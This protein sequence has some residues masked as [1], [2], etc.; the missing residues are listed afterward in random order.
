MGEGCLG[1]CGRCAEFLGESVERVPVATVIADLDCRVEGGPC[2]GDR[3]S[4]EEEC[5]FVES[6]GIEGVGLEACGVGLVWNEVP[7]LPGVA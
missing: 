7:S 5:D 1:S 6:G 2:S 3:A 4:K